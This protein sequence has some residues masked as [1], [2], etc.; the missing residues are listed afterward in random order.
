MKTSTSGPDFSAASYSGW[1]PVLEF[2]KISA[3]VEDNA[4]LTAEYAMSAP[5]TPGT[6]YKF[7]YR[8]V[9]GAGNMSDWME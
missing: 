3:F 7:R 8:V 9:D 5:R 2:S 1:I 4:N 6:A